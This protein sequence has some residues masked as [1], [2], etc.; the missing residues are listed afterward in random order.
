MLTKIRKI[1][2]KFEGNIK[3]S[4]VIEVYKIDRKTY[5]KYYKLLIQQEVIN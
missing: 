3:G 2:R 5:Y 1:A 4:E